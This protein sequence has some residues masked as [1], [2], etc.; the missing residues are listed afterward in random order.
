MLG[1]KQDLR[2]A[3]DAKDEGP[4]LSANPQLR[5]VQPLLDHTKLEKARCGT[6]S[7]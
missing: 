6:G 2:D 3:H 4:E 7:R 1:W 5:A